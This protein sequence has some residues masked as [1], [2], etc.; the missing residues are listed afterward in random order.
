[1]YLKHSQTP[2]DPILLTK[3]LSLLHYGSLCTLLLFLINYEYLDFKP[4][5]LLFYDSISFIILIDLVPI[6]SL[7]DL[8]PAFIIIG[9]IIYDFIFYYLHIHDLIQVLQF[10]A[11]ILGFTLLIIILLLHFQL[12]NS[13]PS[14]IIYS[15]FPPHDVLWTFTKHHLSHNDFIIVF[16]FSFLPTHTEVPLD[17]NQYIFPLKHVI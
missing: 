16:I 10:L 7:Q 11:L 5:F 6:Q 4:Q 17:F 15:F 1:M 12:I 13:V 2:N 3:A 9:S 8:K 14:I